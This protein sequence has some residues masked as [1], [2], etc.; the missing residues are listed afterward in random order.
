MAQISHL[1][2]GREGIFPFLLVLKKVALPK[3]ILGCGL[4]NA[5]YKCSQMDEISTMKKYL[6]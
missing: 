2:G 6:Q 3:I 5:G 1:V 4:E